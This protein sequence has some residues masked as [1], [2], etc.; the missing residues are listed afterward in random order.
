MQNTWRDFESWMKDDS[1]IDDYTKQVYE[2]AV[3]KLDQRMQYE[4]SL[5]EY[6]EFLDYLIIYMH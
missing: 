4:D 5:V 2:Q 6:K 1:S 3:E